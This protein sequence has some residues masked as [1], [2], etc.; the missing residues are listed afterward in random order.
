MSD[1]KT[2]SEALLAQPF[3]EYNIERILDAFYHCG[4]PYAFRGDAS[5]EGSFKRAIANEISS[6]YSLRCHPHDLVVCGSAHLGFSAA[7]T[8]KLGK[9]FD[10]NT[11][12][13][14]VAVLLPELFDRWWIELA[15]PRTTLG[16]CRR[17]ISQ[18]LMNGYINPSIVRDITTI[19][20]RW[21]KLFHNFP[22]IGVSKVRGRIYRNA[23]FMQNY[24][25]LSV[26]RGRARLQGARG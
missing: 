14:D 20:K 6:A 19:G 12:D 4:V 11:S 16:D 15:D 22:A 1:F 5:A 2:Y 7:P 10:F 21:W 9:A 26:T 3:D 24:H 25:R 18:H 17:R 8:E 13:I 23:Q